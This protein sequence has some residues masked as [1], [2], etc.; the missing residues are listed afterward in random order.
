ME[1]VFFRHRKGVQFYVAGYLGFVTLN[2]KETDALIAAVKLVR[3]S[4]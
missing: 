3:K 4:N 1:F 2:K